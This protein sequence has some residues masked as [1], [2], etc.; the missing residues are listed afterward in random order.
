M[1]RRLILVIT[2]AALLG[3]ASEA[4]TIRRGKRGRKYLRHLSL[5]DNLQNDKSIIYTEYGYP[6]HRI[7]VRGY[8]TVKEHWR[9]LELGL[10]FVFDENSNLVKT[11]HFW[12]EDRRERFKR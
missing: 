4:V 9:Y 10:E 5:V 1:V 7:R 12:P 8:G 6:F 11:K 2:L 3:T